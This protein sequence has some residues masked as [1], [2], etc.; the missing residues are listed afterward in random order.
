MFFHHMLC[1]HAFL[2][3]VFLLVLP[4]F[5]YTRFFIVFSTM[6]STK[7][8]A[9]PIECKRPFGPMVMGFSK[10]CFRSFAKP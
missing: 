10:A 7:E 1:S 6:D 4:V 3:L 9:E 5:I 8:W 2:C